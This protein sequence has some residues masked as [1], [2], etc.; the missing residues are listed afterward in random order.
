[1]GDLFAELYGAY[2]RQVQLAKRK[3]EKVPNMLWS[4]T[5][6]HFR[7][8]LNHSDAR[9]YFRLIPTQT[10]FG[11]PFVENSDQ[12]ATWAL[13]TLVDKQA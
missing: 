6:E 1:M 3:G 2:M 11:V 5:P 12:L 8:L 13:Y 7:V 9:Q 4:F 10:V